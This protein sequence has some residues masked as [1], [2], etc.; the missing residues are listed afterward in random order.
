MMDASQ[1]LPHVDRRVPFD[2]GITLLSL[3]K[4]ERVRVVTTTGVTAPAWSGIGYVQA[5]EDDD[6][7][8]GTFRH[9]RVHRQVQERGRVGVLG[10][11]PRRPHLARVG[12]GHVDHQGRV[13][14][15]MGDA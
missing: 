10:H 11:R 7:E 3:F 12:R 9:G 6:A 2:V 8:D 13:V 14:G 1:D 4:G 15:R 5:I